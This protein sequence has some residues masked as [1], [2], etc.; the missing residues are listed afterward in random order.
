MK[1]VRGMIQ[2]GKM[3]KDGKW[4]VDEIV[5]L[6]KHHFISSKP[7]VYLVNID[8]KEYINKMNNEFLPEIKNYLKE[9]KLGEMVPYSAEFEKDCLSQAAHPN[10]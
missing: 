5:M 7:Q 8:K 1:R 6:N 2:E 9:K 4:T 10:D 3:V